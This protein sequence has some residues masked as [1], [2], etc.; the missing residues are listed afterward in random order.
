[1]IQYWEARISLNVRSQNLC[2]LCRVEKI[3]KGRFIGFSM[4]RPV[5]LGIINH[6][7]Q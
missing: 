3:K 5:E 2:G 6:T 7:A 1:M 4:N